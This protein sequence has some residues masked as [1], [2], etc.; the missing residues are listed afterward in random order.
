M[1]NSH[2]VNAATSFNYTPP[3]HLD[4]NDFEWSQVSVLKDGITYGGWLLF[5][6]YQI[7]FALN[8]TDSIFF[9]AERLWHGTCAMY[10]ESGAIQIGLSTQLSHTLINKESL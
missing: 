2:Y 1:C 10:H 8:H 3:I 6:Q 7:G 5:P 4:K 9:P